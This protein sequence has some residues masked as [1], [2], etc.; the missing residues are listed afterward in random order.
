MARV[1]V[2]LGVGVLVWCERWGAGLR[3]VTCD[4]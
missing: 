4:A 3:C 1:G 2:A